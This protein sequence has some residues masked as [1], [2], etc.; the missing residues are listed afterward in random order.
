MRQQVL[1]GENKRY[2]TSYTL[3]VQFQIARHY[4]VIISISMTTIDDIQNGTLVIYNYTNV[5][6]FV[7]SHKLVTNVS[8]ESKE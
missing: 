8:N 3:N 5:D 6:I 4:S 7:E 1:C 2:C